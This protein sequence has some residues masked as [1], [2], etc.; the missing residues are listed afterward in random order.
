MAV[1]TGNL[2]LTLFIRDDRLVFDYNIFT[3]HHVVRTRHPLP[4][5]ETSVGVHFHRDGDTGTATLFVDG[6]ASAT[7]AV[8]FV[9]RVLGSTG[10]DVGRDALSTVS[11][12]YQGPFPFNGTLHELTIH[13]PE[14]GTDEMTEDAVL[15]MRT[16][17]AR[18]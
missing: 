18:E 11:E 10:L 2:G 5:G 8:P 17:L 4:I 7:M 13:L 1:G 9:V 3:D 12:E 16:E 6:E 15:A 14:R